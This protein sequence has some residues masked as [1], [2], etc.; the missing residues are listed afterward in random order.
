MDD[1]RDYAEEAFNQHILDTGDGEIE[2]P[3]RPVR[4][5]WG[6]HGSDTEYVHVAKLLTDEPLNGI[7]DPRREA[8]FDVTLYDKTVIDKK[9]GND[10]EY[11]SL[12]DLRELIGYAN[13]ALKAG[14]EP[15]P[16]PDRTD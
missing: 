13:A 6:Y 11:Q 10:S 12:C 16:V 3:R 1:Q 7:F 2:I 8:L 15:E 14:L 5:D 9:T 4:Y